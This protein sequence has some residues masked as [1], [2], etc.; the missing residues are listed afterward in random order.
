DGDRFAR[1]D[2][3]RIDRVRR[4]VRR[5]ARVRDAGKTGDRLRRLQGF[6]LAHLALG[7]HT[8]EAAFGQQRDTGRVITAVFERLEAADQRCDD[9]APGGGTDNSTHESKIPE[10]RQA[11][12]PRPY[13]V[14]AC[15]DPLP[16]EKSHAPVRVNRV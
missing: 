6:E 9:I 7:A 15:C 4:T 8:L 13:A 1:C 10:T 5:P 12:L 11:I 3:M 14:R 16:A 2:R